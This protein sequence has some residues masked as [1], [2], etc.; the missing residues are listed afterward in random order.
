MN[1]S[2]TVNRADQRGS[3]VSLSK[4][5]VAIL[6][7]L[8]CFIV[9]AFGGTNA[10][11]A[12][13]VTAF[14]M[15]PTT[16]ASATGPTGAPAP[17]QAGGHPSVKFNID[18]DAVLADGGSSASDDDDLKKVTYEFPAGALGNPEAAT[19]KCTDASF[20]ADTCPTASYIG[21][22]AVPLRL[23][24]VFG[25]YTTLNATGSMYIMAPA[26]PSSPITV[27]FIVR[28]PGYRLIFIKSE[29]KGVV[30]W[31][32]GLDDVY[33]L[34]FS[35]DNIPKTLT[36]TGW[37]GGQVVN[38]TISNI[39]VVL[40]NKA[41]TS[42]SGPYFTYMPT[43]CDAAQVKATVTSYG[44]T[45]APTPIVKQ[46]SDSFTPTN[47]LQ[48]PAAPTQ[49]Y[50]PFQPTATV[51]PSSTVA[52]DP[53]NWTANFTNPN[54]AATATNSPAQQTAP[55]AIEA[56]H[57]KSISSDLPVGTQ[58]NSPA[59]TAIPAICT[60]ADVNADNCPLGS[61]I[62]TASAYVPLLPGTNPNSSVVGSTPNFA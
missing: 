38:A 57:I 62:G 33:G 34:T 50:V 6:A 10:D 26:T 40:N 31:K 16:P 41:N 28:P 42:A 19:T 1:W 2:P 54:I 11:A 37:L 18:P 51:T 35:V 23:K 60:E 3:T 27:G 21:S 36:T 15:Q 52:S 22:L 4:V 53:V 59:I 29:V 25:S 49:K 9:I 61:K 5:A 17:L 7:A 43:R 32:S 30:A 20:N 48:N 44:S 12:Y 55:Q 8:T 58:L 39:T 46:L 13:N 45:A 14:K 24:N 56:S 47:C